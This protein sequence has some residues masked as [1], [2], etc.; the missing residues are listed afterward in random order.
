MHEISDVIFSLVINST[1]VAYAITLE[2]PISDAA[3]SWYFIREWGKK[4]KIIMLCSKCIHTKVNHGHGRKL[5]IASVQM[6]NGREKTMTADDTRYRSLS[7]STPPPF[8]SFSVT[9]TLTALFFARAHFASSGFRTYHCTLCYLQ[10]GTSAA[11]LIYS[12]ILYFFPKVEK[13]LLQFE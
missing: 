12:R 10:Q 1:L 11:P 2:N 8:L 4:R 13:P 3:V 6:E 5:N 9:H 7:I